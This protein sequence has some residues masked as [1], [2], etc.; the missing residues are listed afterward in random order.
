MKRTTLS[1]LL[2]LGTISVCAQTSTHLRRVEV[3]PGTSVVKKVHEMTDDGVV[4]PKF[5]G[6][7]DAL[8]NY[9]RT[10]IKYP[11]EAEEKGI[12]GRVLCAFVVDE[13]GSISDIEIRESVDALLDNEAE[14]VVRNMP[15]WI[16]G[17]KDGWP[18]KVRFILPV[19]FRLGKN[20]AKSDS[21]VA[22]KRKEPLPE[23]TMPTFP[24]GT[25]ALLT[26]LKNHLR[27]PASAKKFG[28]EGRVIC[29]YVVDTDGSITDVKVVKSVSPDLDAEA[30]RVIRQMPKW[31]P[32]HR[33]G[34]PQKVNYT[35]PITF[36]L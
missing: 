11:V 6:G 21:I 34:T 23:L 2:L 5:P 28:E 25:N 16:A 31:N 20:K 14:R 29:S 32:G 17:T 13:K 15:N 26:Y 22:A 8:M 9:L 33:N 19:T 36:R 27:Y 4:V 12:H 10:N 18:V 3:A 30:V 7:M 35:M 24:G 1:L